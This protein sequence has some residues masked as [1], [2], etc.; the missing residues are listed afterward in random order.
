MGMIVVLGAFLVTQK[1]EVPKEAGTVVS[2]LPDRKSIEPI[3]S[4]GD[5][6]EDWKEDLQARVIA[7]IQVPTSTPG[8]TS[9]LLYEPPT[10]FTGKFAEAFF[11]DYIAGKAQNEEGIDKELIVENAIKA[12]DANARSRTYQV[13]DITIIP[14]SPEAVKQYGNRIAH[15]ITRTSND[16]GTTES[17]ILILKRALETK[18]PEALQELAPI[19]EAYAKFVAETLKVPVPASFSLSHLAL[20]NSYEAIRT[21]VS[22]MEQA[23]T[24]PILSLARLQHYEADATSLFESLKRIATALIAHGVT[25][26]NDEPGAII[27]TLDI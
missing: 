12:I 8:D 20:L 4:D 23:F 11:T 14:D 5:G 15:I 7:S 25:Y 9:T 26:E 21:D 17:E 6:I 18:N 24:D 10:T 13:R 27:Y 2:A 19:R 1:S 3:D 16:T 22:T